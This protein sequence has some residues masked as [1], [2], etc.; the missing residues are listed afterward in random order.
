MRRLKKM[1]VNELY[2]QGAEM[3]DYAFIENAFFDARWLIEA[4]IG[5]EPDQFALKKD[6]PVS[7]KDEV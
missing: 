2:R 6:K 4:A 7:K 5:I 1:T 3:L